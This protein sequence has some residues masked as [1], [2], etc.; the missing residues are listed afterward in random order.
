MSKKREAPP[1]PEELIKKLE[2]KFLEF[3]TETESKQE[4]QGKVNE[5]LKASVEEIKASQSLFSQ[6][7]DSKLEI[8]S[9]RQSNDL[10]NLRY[11]HK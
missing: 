7:I 3:K 11:E 5:E 2:D 1:K 10:Q 6:E 8:L 9:E 4:E